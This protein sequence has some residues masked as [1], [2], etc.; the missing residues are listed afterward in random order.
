MFCQQLQESALLA[1]R[2]VNDSHIPIL[3]TN[4]GFRNDPDIICCSR[5]LG[6]IKEQCGFITLFNSSDIRE[7]ENRWSIPVCFFIFHPRPCSAINQLIYCISARTLY[8]Y[9]LSSSSKLSKSDGSN[10]RKAPNG[11]KFFEGNLHATWARQIITRLRRLHSEHTAMFS[12]DWYVGDLIIF[13][14][15]F[16]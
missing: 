7:H 9:I 1:G 8:S 5:V 16:L 14:D 4:A 11:L 10:I 15:A 12:Y 6:S 13:G 3:S 2:R